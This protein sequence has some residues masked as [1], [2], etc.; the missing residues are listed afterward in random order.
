MPQRPPTP[1]EPIHLYREK[2]GQREQ[3][4]HE[5]H[6][7]AGFA[8]ERRGRDDHRHDFAVRN[9]LGLLNGLFDPFTFCIG[10]L[11]H[12]PISR[13]PASAEVSAPATESATTT[14]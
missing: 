9:P 12:L 5:S 3:G 11:L 4:E 8:V 10:E 1:G 13:G 7:I 2:E 6:S 14:K